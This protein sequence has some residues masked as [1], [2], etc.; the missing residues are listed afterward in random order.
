MTEIGNAIL[1]ECDHLTSVTVMPAVPPTVYENGMPLNW[2]TVKYPILV[3]E[4]SLAAYQNADGWRYQ[5]TYQVKPENHIGTSESMG[6]K[7]WD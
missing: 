5:G 4:G 1:S 3:P 2:N 6:E 7:D